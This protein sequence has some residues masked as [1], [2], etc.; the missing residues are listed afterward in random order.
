MALHRA[1]YLL[2]NERRRFESGGVLIVGP[3]RVFTAVRGAGAALARR[4]HRPRCDRSASCWTG[5]HATR[6]EPAALAAIKGALTMLPVLERAVRTAPPGVPDVFRTTYQGHVVRLDQQAL[7]QARSVALGRGDSANSGN[8]GGPQPNALRANGATARWR[9]PGSSSRASCG[10]GA[11]RARAL[12][13]GAAGPDRV[14]LFLEQWSAVPRPGRGADGLADEATLR[15][16]AGPDL[17]AEQI[18]LL[19]ASW[20]GADSS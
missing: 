4:A 1:A 20:R 2:F 13:P 18:V 17:A 11:G 19:A 3:S 8:G 16:L 10:T 6:H 12:R 5:V 14:D 15:A 9:P 7:D